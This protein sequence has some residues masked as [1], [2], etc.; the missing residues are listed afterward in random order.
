MIVG[1][2]PAQLPVTDRTGAVIH[3]VGPGTIYV[4]AAPTVDST[5]GIP[6]APGDRLSI[7]GP[8]AAA[9][10]SGLWVVASE[11]GTDVRVLPTAA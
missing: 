2:T 8:L 6:V 11:A 10:L 9:G 7:P 3:N 5:T 1:T 4:G